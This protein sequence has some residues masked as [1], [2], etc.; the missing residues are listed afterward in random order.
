[1]KILA[2]SDT[3]LEFPTVADLPDA[4]VLVHAG[5]WTDLGFRHSGLEIQSFKHFLL[6][7]HEK[8]PTVPALH[9]NHGL[10][11]DN[12]RWRDWGVT[13]IDGL[14]W[15]HPSGIAFIAR[16]AWGRVGAVTGNEEN[17]NDQLKKL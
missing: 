17:S 3:H 13:P 9:G 11:F 15:T 1:M 16:T 10:G 4:D 8:Y 14:T 7:L 5:Y 2:L 6:D 12:G